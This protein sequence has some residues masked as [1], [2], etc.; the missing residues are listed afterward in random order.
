MNA[1]DWAEFKFQ[2]KMEK[3]R[4]ERNVK[5]RAFAVNYVMMFAVWLFTLVPAYMV[6]VQNVMRMNAD[7]AHFFMLDL[8][9]IGSILNAVFFLAPA[10]AIWWE[11]AACKKKKDM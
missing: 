4:T 7:E 10:F 9:G 3:L 11:M 6:M 2:K 1:K 8:L 5:F